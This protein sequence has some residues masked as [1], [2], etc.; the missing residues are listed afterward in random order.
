VFFKGLFLVPFSCSFYKYK[1]KE[2]DIS[3]RKKNKEVEEKKMLDSNM[4]SGL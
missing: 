2:N 4:P 1:K 3:K